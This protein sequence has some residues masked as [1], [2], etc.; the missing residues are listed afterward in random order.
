[1]TLPR[2]PPDLVV[3]YADLDEQHRGLLHGVDVT[4]QAVRAGDLAA[5]KTAMGELGSDLVA[6]FAAEESFMTTT[7]YPEL[8]RHKA[9]HDLFMHDFLQLGRELEANGLSPAAIEGVTRRMPDWLRFHIRV[10]DV[11]LGRY[12]SARRVRTDVPPAGSVKPRA[13]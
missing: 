9:A 12:L 2:V 13:S 8:P 7:R 3:G 4:V 11:P 1:M 5:A 10:N 6:H